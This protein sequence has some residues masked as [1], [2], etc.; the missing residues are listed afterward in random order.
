MVYELKHAFLLDGNNLTGEEN[1]SDGK[2]GDTWEIAKWIAREEQ[3]KRKAKAKKDPSYKPEEWTFDAV[4]DD[5]VFHIARKAIEKKL[6]KED[7]AEFRKQKR[8]LQ[9]RVGRYMRA[10]KKHLDNVCEGRFP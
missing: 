6:R 8:I 2:K 4:G 9:S 3:P 5:W 1:E 7:Q 10:A